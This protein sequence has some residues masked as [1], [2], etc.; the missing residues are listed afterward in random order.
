[1]FSFGFVIIANLFLQEHGNHESLMKTRGLYD[2]LIRLQEASGSLTY[3]PHTGHNLAGQTREISPMN[4]SSQSSSSSVDERDTDNLHLR[5]I[6]SKKRESASYGPPIHR[7]SEKDDG[8]TLSKILKIN[9]PEL[10]YIIF[11]FLGSVILGLST[12]LLAIV[13]GEILGLLNPNLDSLEAHIGNNF[14]SLVRNFIYFG[15]GT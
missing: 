5:L 11:G 12:P 14:L 15:G 2:E 7:N 4:R 6:D 10:S 13:L 9:R 3:D 1:M 8:A